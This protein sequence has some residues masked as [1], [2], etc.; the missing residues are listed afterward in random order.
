MTVYNGLITDT[1]YP[2]TNQFDKFT[3]T[4]TDTP[5]VQQVPHGMYIIGVI[6]S[7]DPTRTDGS[8]GAV[9]YYAMEPAWLENL[10]HQLLSD[11]NLHTMGFTDALGNVLVA[12]VSPETLKTLY[13]PYQYIVSCMWFPI[14]SAQIL[15][16]TYAATLKIGWWTYAVANYWLYAQTVEL[17]EDVGLLPWHPQATSRGNYL[18]HAPYTQTTLMGRFGMIALDDKYIRAGV[19]RLRLVYMIDLVEGLCLLKLVS[20]YI[21]SDNVI[22]DTLFSI[23]T[24]QL[25]VPI[26]LAQVGVDYLGTSVTQ[27]NALSGAVNSVVSGSLAAA[28]GDIGGIASSFTGIVGSISNGIYNSLNASMPQMETSGSNGSFISPFMLTTL[29]QVYYFLALEDIHHKGRPVCANKQINTLS[30]Y[31]L[32]AEGDFDIACLDIERNMI[33]NFLT[34][35]FFYE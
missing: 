14:T 24:F 11:D 27:V 21:D 7:G 3:R 2:T 4:I 1:V 35:G 32:C 29:T 33:K 8:V 10:K 5:F 34:S 16:K 6:N 31:I 15:Q 30:G 26:Q 23:R 19:D 9:T 20:R 17:S 18:N 22:T 12:D 13:N 28:G 25:G